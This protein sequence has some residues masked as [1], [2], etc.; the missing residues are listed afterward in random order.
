MVERA[1]SPM[2]QTNEPVGQLDMGRLNT[3][4]YEG[5]YYLDDAQSVYCSGIRAKFNGSTPAQPRL[6]HSRVLQ[7]SVKR[8]LDIAL[9]AA[10]LVLLGPLMVILAVMVKMSS[11]GG[12]F[13]HQEREGIDGKP[14]RILKYRTMY[15]D[16]GDVSGVNQ[17]TEGDARVTSL[18]RIMRRTSLDELPQLFNVVLGDMSIVGPRPHVKGQLA[19]GRPYR[20]LVPYYEARHAMR[21][22]LTGWAQANGLRGPTDDR[23]RSKAR[24]DYDIAYVQNFSLWLDAVIILRTLK[25]EFLT[26]SGS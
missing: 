8:F 17:T 6:D 5:D 15:I 24:I 21:P 3:Q 4:S 11:P 13:F 25:T 23:T 26:G 9:V 1:A 20:E 16:Q 14:F 7:L 22:G 18:G 2:P 12:V 10:S 19:A